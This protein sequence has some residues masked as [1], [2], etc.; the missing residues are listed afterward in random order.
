VSDLKHRGVLISNLKDKILWKI[1]LIQE[2]VAMAIAV[3][4]VA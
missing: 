2:A 4:A 3:A 1:N